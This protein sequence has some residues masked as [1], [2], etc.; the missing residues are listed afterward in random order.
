MKRER[1]KLTRILVGDRLD[2]LLLSYNDI[3]RDGLTK[4]VLG[5]YNVYIS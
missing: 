1:E 5:G 3:Q 4:G 2:E